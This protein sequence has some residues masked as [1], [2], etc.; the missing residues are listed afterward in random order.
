M[1]DAPASTDTVCNELGLSGEAFISH[2][3]GSYSGVMG[4]PLHETARLLREFGIDCPRVPVAP[5]AV[6]LG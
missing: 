1:I 6:A 3:S 5:P 2:L 4:L